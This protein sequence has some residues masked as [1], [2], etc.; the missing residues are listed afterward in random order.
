MASQRLGDYIPR[1]EGQMLGLSLGL[2]KKVNHL[3][4][5]GFLELFIPKKKKKIEAYYYWSLDLVMRIEQ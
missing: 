1:S 5:S 3:L 2:A 4:H